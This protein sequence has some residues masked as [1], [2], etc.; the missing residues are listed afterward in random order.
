M[1]RM[2]IKK[3]I[4]LVAAFMVLTVIVYGAYTIYQIRNPQ[5]LFEK[6]SMTEEVQPNGQADLTAPAATEEKGTNQLEGTDEFKGDRVNVLLLGFDLAPERKDMGVF[7]T[8][9]AIIASID[10]NNSQVYMLSIPRD[11]YVEI[12]GFEGRYKYND[13]FH[14]GGSFEGKGFEKAMETASAFI[15]GIPV[16]YYMGVDMTVFKVVI[17]LIGGIEYDVDVP[18]VMNGR[19]LKAGKQILTGQQALDYARNR[20]TKLADIDRIDRQQRILLATFEQ[21]KSKTQLSKIPEIFLGVKDD[22]W[23]NMNVKQISGLALFGT[24]IDLNRIRRYTIPGGFL[25]YKGV[26]YWGIKQYEKAKLIE[27]IFGVKIEVNPTDDIGY[28]REQ[29]EAAQGENQQTSSN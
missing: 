23:T 12:P 20:H 19:E 8:D 7:R 22:I 18:V 28:L 1:K 27:E 21:L 5:T 15:G 24:N 13:A 11:S 26:S 17:D 2:P 9:T 25:T 16:Q 29:V 3:I 6:S 14:M 10:F 4:L